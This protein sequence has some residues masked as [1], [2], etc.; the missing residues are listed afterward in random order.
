MGGRPVAALGP[1][2]VRVVSGH[3]LNERGVLLDLGQAGLIDTRSTLIAV[4]RHPRTP[5]D[6]PA[7]DL[8]SKHMKPSP[9]IGLG[10]R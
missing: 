5:Q 4:H 2:R 3:N 1:H 9:G 7:E 8:V 10:R 6:V